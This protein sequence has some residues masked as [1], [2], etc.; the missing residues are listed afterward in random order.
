LNERTNYLPRIP[1]LGY[2]S[3]NFWFSLLLY[4][5]ERYTTV[6]PS[7]IPLIGIKNNLP[8][9]SVSFYIDNDKII[10]THYTYYDLEPLMES[11]ELAVLDTTDTNFKTVALIDQCPSDYYVLWQDRTGSY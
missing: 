5:D 6:Y 7:E 9:D 1:Q 10:N 4:R 11:D 8:I 3:Q 2:T